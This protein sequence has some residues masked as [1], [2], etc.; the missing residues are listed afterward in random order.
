MDKKKLN[1][2]GY[3]VGSISIVA[4]LFL[5]GRLDRGIGRSL[6]GIIGFIVFFLGI[7]FIYCRLYDKKEIFGRVF[8]IISGVSCPLLYMQ[9]LDIF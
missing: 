3:V 9:H 6:G 5:I 8:G 7:T 2:I 4:W 1:I